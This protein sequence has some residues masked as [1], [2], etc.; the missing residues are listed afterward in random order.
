MK[1]KI[2]CFI[3][4]V[5]KFMSNSTAEIINATRIFNENRY[6]QFSNTFNDPILTTAESVKTM[7]FG[8]CVISVG[9]GIIGIGA[10]IVFKGSLMKKEMEVIKQ[11]DMHSLLKKVT[12]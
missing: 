11:W 9:V 5:R 4:E 8:L 3:K 2:F 6:N 7:A 1:D 10:S 12:V